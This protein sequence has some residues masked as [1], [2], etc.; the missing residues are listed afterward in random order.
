MGTDFFLKVVHSCFKY[1][2]DVSSE[3]QKAKGSLDASSPVAQPSVVN[4]Q[5]VL[6]G[7]EKPGV[8]RQAVKALGK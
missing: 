4:Y 8:S 6:Q 7:A 1:D 3:G 5:L 2:C